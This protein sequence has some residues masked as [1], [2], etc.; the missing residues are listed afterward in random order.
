MTDM[1]VQKAD[2]KSFFGKKYYFQQLFSVTLNKSGFELGM[3]CSQYQCPRPLSYD[4]IQ[5]S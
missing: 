5:E 3:C 4:D 2:E 1:D